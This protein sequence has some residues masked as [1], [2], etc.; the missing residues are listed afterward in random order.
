MNWASM[1]LSD[2][3]EGDH[4]N[5]GDWRARHWARAEPSTTAT[6]R[7]A[8]PRIVE[9]GGDLVP[10]V[11]VLAQNLCADKIGRYIEG[12]GSALD[13]LTVV[14]GSGGA[15]SAF[16][17]SAAIWLHAERL[18]GRRAEVKIEIHANKADPD[19]VAA[20]EKVI[21]RYL[22]E[23]GVAAGDGGHEA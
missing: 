16:A 14:V 4:S 13:V 17:R 18:R 12:M 6:S 8:A 20:A 9:S 2:V 11:G 10:A 23:R 15:I 5:T 21:Q 3:R 7:R 22:S 1:R 19:S